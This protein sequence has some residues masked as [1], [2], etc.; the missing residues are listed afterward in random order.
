MTNAHTPT[1]AILTTTLN[2]LGVH[3]IAGQ[4]DTYSEIDE[5]PVALLRGLAS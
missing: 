2:Q 5:S 4:A 1:N 3:F